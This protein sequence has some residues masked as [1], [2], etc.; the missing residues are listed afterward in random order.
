VCYLA[1][2]LSAHCA[3]RV[4]A[5]GEG[6]TGSGRSGCRIK[7]YKIII[8]ETRADMQFDLRVVVVVYR[9]G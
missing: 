7:F 1:R 9:Q 8:S 3:S 2:C 5:S 6:S 4:V